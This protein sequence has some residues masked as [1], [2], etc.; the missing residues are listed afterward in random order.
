MPSPIM[1]SGKRIIR[2]IK[3]T[4]W[5]LFWRMVFS[6]KANFPFISVWFPEKAAGFFQFA[7]TM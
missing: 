1:S 6:K 7:V 5:L 2:L 4:F 3:I